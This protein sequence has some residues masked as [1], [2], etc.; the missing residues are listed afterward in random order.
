L[1]CIVN[2]PPLYHCSILPY[3]SSWSAS[4]TNFVLISPFNTCSC[5][6]FSPPR[7]IWPFGS[8]LIY[9]NLYV[10]VY[11]SL[12]MV[13]CCFWLW[14]WFGFWFCFWFWF[15]TS[16]SDS[17]SDSDSFSIS[18]RSWMDVLRESLCAVCDTVLILFVALLLGWPSGQIA[19]WQK[20]NSVCEVGAQL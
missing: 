2:D 3:F 18:A 1:Q 8:Q 4:K 16:N 10:F 9:G 7:G 17:D 12:S 6:I 20:P 13:C 19:K 14:I 11:L 5:V 15:S